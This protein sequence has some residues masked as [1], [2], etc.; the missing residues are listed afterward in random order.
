MNGAM[1]L[2]IIVLGWFIGAVYLG[3]KWDDIET[4]EESSYGV[5]IFCWPIVIPI[6]LTFM[7][8]VK[9]REYKDA[10]KSAGKQEESSG[11]SGAN[12]SRYYDPD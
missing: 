6:A 3:W 8:G 10:K 5:A 1:I 9:L 4:W 2:F 11:T 12:Q 7:L